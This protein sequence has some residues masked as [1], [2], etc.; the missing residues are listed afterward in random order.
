MLRKTIHF[1]GTRVYIQK[2][3]YSTNQLVLLLMT[4]KKINK[5]CTMKRFIILLAT[6]IIILLSILLCLKGDPSNAISN[7]TNIVSTFCSLGTLILAILLYNKYGIDSKLIEKNTDIVFKLVR[8]FNKLFF[9]VEGPESNNY[10]LIVHL[11]SKNQNEIF[12]EF[13]NQPI[14]FTKDYFRILDPIIS[15]CNDPFMPPTIVEASKLLSV[16]SIVGIK[17]YHNKYAIIKRD[18]TKL[19]NDNF[20]GLLNDKEMT[21]GE[22]ITAFQEFKNVIK[23]WLQ[24]H[25]TNSVEMNF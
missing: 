20:V 3:V 16:N 14:C 13:F 12:S 8:E 9:I 2:S 4:K 15:L 7:G 17:D 25:S 24:L 18:A 19:S 21:L 10:I 6:V 23:Q 11:S 5:F 1:F 22:Y